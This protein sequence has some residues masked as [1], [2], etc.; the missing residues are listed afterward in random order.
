MASRSSEARER[1]PTSTVRRPA[2]VAVPCCV[3]SGAA[4]SARRRHRRRR[5]DRCR[6]RGAR[7][8]DPASL[9]QGSGRAR[10]AG[11]ARCSPSCGSS[12]SSASSS[13][14]NWRRSSANAASVAAAA[15]RCERR[16]A[17]ARADGPPKRAA[18]YRGRARS[19]LQARTAP[20]TGACCSTSTTCNRSA[21]P[22]DRVGADRHRSRARARAPADAR[23]AGQGARDAPGARQAS[24]RRSQ[25]AGHSAP[26]AADRAV[27][28]RTDAGRLDRRAARPECA[29]DRRAPGRTAEA[30]GIARPRLDGGAV[31]ASRCRCGRFKGPCPGRPA[32]GIV[33]A[34]RPPA[35]QPFWH[36]HRQQ[37]DRD[38]RRRRD[39]PSAPSTRGWSRLPIRSRLRQ[40]RDRGSRGRRLLALR[41][42]GS[43]SA[44]PR[45]TGSRR[46]RRSALSGR[47]PAGNPALYFELRIDGTAVDPL[48]W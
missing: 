6:G 46:R 44:S 24:S 10:R 45:G 23:G 1:A 34:V 13:A 5:R 12:R 40:P 28:A 2:C 38:W 27:A 26:G 17:D 47:I 41:L 48:Q 31:A 37:R 15:G 39:S 32:A 42:S 8:T 7:P 19:G 4:A 11:A 3:L 33:G 22:T 25:D 16:R 14:R 18:G 35:E 29:A 30:A 43:R 9:Q 20:A 21:A 36:G